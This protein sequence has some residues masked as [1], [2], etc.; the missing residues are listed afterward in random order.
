MLALLAVASPAGGQP[1]PP[2]VEVPIEAVRLSDGVHRYGVRISVGGKMVLAGIDTGASGLRLMPDGAA[3]AA[4]SD[5]GTAENFSFGSG[6]RPAGTV[7]RARIAIGALAGEGSVQLVKAVDCAPGR[8]NCP[9]RLGLGYGFLGDGLPGEGFRVLL[10]GAMGPTSIDSPFAV[11]G[12]RRWI[13]EVPRPGESGPGRLILNP[14]D[15]EVADYVKVRLVGGHAESDGGGLHDAVFGCLRQVSN[16]RRLCGL[17]TLDTGAF[18]VRVLNAPPG[19]PSFATGEAL[20][21]EFL[22]PD[23]TSKASASMVVGR[24]AQLVAPGSAP[25]N[26]TILQLGIGPYYAYSVLYDPSRRWLGLKARPAV[27]GLPAAVKSGE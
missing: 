17:T 9:G 12:A 8:P 27:E 19:G 14:T 18:G 16:G 23:R 22:D 15:A 7:G 21:M 2:R 26:Q 4:V 11:I 5:T 13:I 25:R 20:S 3:G 10:G 24:T 1:T 6:A